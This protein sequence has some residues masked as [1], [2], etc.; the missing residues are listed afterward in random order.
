MSYSGGPENLTNSHTDE[1]N[2]PIYG[3][4][5]GTSSITF[6]G[7]DASSTRSQWRTSFF[8]LLMSG[9]STNSGVS[10]L[11]ESVQIDEIPLPTK[12]PR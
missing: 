10:G 5:A 12:F 7:D 2:Y 6:S 9:S 3:I 1:F 11:P 4:N 8:D